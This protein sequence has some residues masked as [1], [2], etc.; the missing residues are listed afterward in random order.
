MRARGD[1]CGFVCPGAVGDLWARLSARNAPQAA[2]GFFAPNQTF[3]GD[4]DNKPDTAKLAILLVQFQAD[5]LTTTTDS[6]QF[7]EFASNDATDTAIVGGRARTMA[8]RLDTFYR[9]VSYGKLSVQSKVFDTL[10][11][12][13]SGNMTAYMNSASAPTALD[14]LLRESFRRVDTFVN[15]ASYDAVA[16]LHAGMA[17]QLGSSSLQNI[18]A[19]L[20]TMETA[21]TFSG[22]GSGETVTMAVL[23][24]LD[25]AVVSSETVTMFGTLAHEFGHVLGLPDLYNTS[26][27][28]QTRGIGKWGLM[29]TGNYL[30]TP[31]GDSPAWMDAWC[32][33]YLSW[34]ETIVLDSAASLTSFDT[35]LQKAEADSKIFKIYP[36]TTT[37][38][39]Y[40]LLE[41][42]EPSSSGLDAAPGSGLLIWHI[43]NTGGVGTIGNNSVNATDNN[44]ATS[45]GRVHLE[46]ADGSRNSSISGLGTSSDAWPNGASNGFGDNSTPNSRGYGDTVARFAIKNIAL[47]SSVT[48]TTDFADV[49][50][51]TG[52]SVKYPSTCLIG[53]LLAPWPSA[54]SAARA[55]RDRLLNSAAGRIIIGVIL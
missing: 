44:T 29:G 15:F 53:R 23:M 12:T 47:G 10:L 31:Q 52:V 42:R 50:V 36:K 2:H 9:A 40:F 6:G 4:T 55:V 46:A 3:G 21:D 43:D 45:H 28:V 51:T 18:P 39:E 20:V 34:A 25:P 27:G 13:L 38:T 33:E 22:G 19:Q 48:F 24:A 5:Q 14:D 54:A 37:K 16:V 11:V 35:K 26:A 49:N 41:D 30:G 17:Q 7:P 32:R 8:D 1:T